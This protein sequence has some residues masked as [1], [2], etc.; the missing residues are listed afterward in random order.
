MITDHWSVIGP[1]DMWHV[2]GFLY[3]DADI[4]PHY[5]PD[6][7]QELTMTLNMEWT[8]LWL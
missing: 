5:D 3:A 6:Q 7:E 2:W 4:E 1:K 8:L